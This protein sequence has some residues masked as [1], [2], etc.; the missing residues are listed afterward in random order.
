[1]VL[2]PLDLLRRQF[3]AQVAD[4]AQQDDRAR[5][6]RG[7]ITCFTDNSFTVN[8]PGA[9]VLFNRGKGH[10]VNLGW[11]FEM[12]VPGQ[13]GAVTYGRV[14]RVGRRSCT[15]KLLQVYQP[16]EPGDRGRLSSN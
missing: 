1:M 9:T 4:A 7:D 3:E 10:G 13:S 15:V 6:V 16:P 5:S 11:S 8:S 14:V 2:Y 12:I